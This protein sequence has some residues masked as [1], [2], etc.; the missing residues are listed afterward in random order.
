[1]TPGAR[2]SEPGR[3]EITTWL[4]WIGVVLLFLLHHDVRF[5][6]APDPVDALWGLPSGFVYHVFYCLV[7]AAWMAV[8]WRAAGP[9][10]SSEPNDPSEW[11]EPS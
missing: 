3:A 1:M 4:A 8:L 11:S 9:S 6:R 7:A 5:W 2:A 10:P